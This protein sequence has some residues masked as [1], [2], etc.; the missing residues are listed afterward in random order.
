MKT[1]TGHRDFQMLARQPLQSRQTHCTVCPK[2]DP[3]KRHQ[4][5]EHLHRRMEIH[6]TKMIKS[7]AK[8]KSRDHLKRLAA[9]KRRTA[10]KK[11]LF[12][13]NHQQEVMA[14]FEQ[15][16]NDNNVSEDFP[17]KLFCALQG[18]YND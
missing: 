11:N 7:P 15:L 10:A 9:E 18:V 5:L 2:S 6:Q 13:L 4:E 1:S 8:K 3:K 17:Q 12:D 14:I 16:M